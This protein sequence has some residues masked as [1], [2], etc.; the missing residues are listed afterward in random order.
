MTKVRGEVDETSLG[1]TPFRPHGRYAGEL[2]GNLLRSVARGPFN[3]Q[4]AQAARKVAPPMYAAAAEQGPFAVLAVFEHS[5]MAN[6]E[7]LEVFADLVKE[8]SARHPQWKGVA[9][10]APQGIEGRGVMNYW[11]SGKC[12]GP[13][14]VAY[15]L[16]EAE[17]E[18]EAWLRSEV[19]V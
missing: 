4:W 19:L 1:D 15:R 16:F 3:L 12:Y 14:G 5:M 2:Q 8:L 7:V 11:F 13:I 10:V 18:A 6:M 9:F 17:A